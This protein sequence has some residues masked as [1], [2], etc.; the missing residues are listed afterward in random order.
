MG[1]GNSLHFYL[2]EYHLILFTFLFYNVRNITLIRLYNLSLSFVCV[3]MG[4]MLRNSN[5]AVRVAEGGMHYFT[6]RNIVNTQKPI[7]MQWFA[8]LEHQGQQ[9]L[10]LEGNWR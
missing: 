2:C 3:Y 10:F 5:S 9:K 8:D 1:T 7:C 4:Y 6:I